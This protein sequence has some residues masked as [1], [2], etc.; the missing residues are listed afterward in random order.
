MNQHKGLARDEALVWLAIYLEDSDHIDEMWG[1]YVEGG[2][3]VHP[4][5]SEFDELVPKVLD[6]L[7][8]QQPLPDIDPDMRDA[9]SQYLADC[10]N[11]IGASEVANT[12]IEGWP[13][14]ILEA[15]VELRQPLL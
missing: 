7:K 10:D 6:A 11:A 3:E 4:S 12:D 8:H 9:F 13:E 14:A 5:R 15:W 2:L 1:N